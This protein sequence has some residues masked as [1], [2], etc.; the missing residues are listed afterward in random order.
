MPEPAQSALLVTYYE[1]LLAD[2]DVE[3][4][5]ALVSAR[6]SEGT[7]ARLIQSSDVRARRA[8]VVSLG[9]IGTFSANSAVAL[10]LKDED[11]TIRDLAVK[12]LWAIWFRADTP[13]NNATLD[14]I[15]SLM[16]RGRSAEAEQLA[17]RL[18]AR[19]PEFAEAY[20][21]RAIAR[22]SQDRFSESAADCR[23]ALEHNP[24]HVGALGGLGQ[25]YIR[26]GQFESALET[27]RRALTLQPHDQGL[28]QAVEALEAGEP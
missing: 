21:Q 18:I 24:Y 27:F 13:E 17:T 7:L 22:F 28:R 10:A 25:C 1:A 2:Q 14:R 8:A 11:P 6:Y 5:E 4:F 12:S 16:A 3:E 20:N 19:A 9:L 26:M 15:A 23:R